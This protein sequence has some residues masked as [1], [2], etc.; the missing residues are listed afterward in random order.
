MLRLSVFDSWYTRLFSYQKDTPELILRK[1]FFLVTNVI[2]IIIFSCVTFLAYFMELRNLAWHIL[3]LL[4]FTLA[5]TILLIIIRKWSRWFVYIV[6]ST[7]IALI[8][9]I[10]ISLGGFASSAGLLMVA[11][12]FLLLIWQKDVSRWL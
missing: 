8:F 5:Q 11:Y 1:K 2:A 4:G 10:I 6:F 12:F 7:Y 3:L 9:C